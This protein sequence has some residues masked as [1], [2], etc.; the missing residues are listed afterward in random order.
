M[1]Q[2]AVTSFSDVDA[3]SGASRTLMRSATMPAGGGG[4]AL[5]LVIIDGESPPGF[6]RAIDW[7]A[8]DRLPN[9][10]LEGPVA[11]VAG[12]LD[13]VSKTPG[14][15]SAQAWI[16]ADVAARARRF[17]DM[18]GTMHL[19]LKLEVIH[20]DACRK[21]HHD[22]VA[23]R[24]VC[25]YRGPGTQ[26]LPRAHEAALGDERDAVPDDWLMAVP[27][28]AAALFTG[29]LL[30]GSRPVLHRSP[31]IAG[32]G[33]LRLVLTINEPFTGRFRG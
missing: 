13:S 31:P 12:W 21:L 9:F 30:P 20:D 8:V 15:L 28:F 6:D 25:T 1:K 27:R 19:A 32:T 2:S 4:A 16:V 33:A 3:G 14:L 26:W 29:V 22:Y 10:R 18:T 24:L 7:L 11:L 5:G 17:A 23:H